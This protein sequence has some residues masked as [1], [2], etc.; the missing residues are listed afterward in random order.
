MSERFSDSDAAREALSALADGEAQSP[1]VARACAAW[2]DQT[3]ARASWHAYQ[4]IGDVMRSEDLAHGSRGD[5]FLKNFRERMAQEPVV[6]APSAAQANRPSVEQ[7]PQ[8]HA[9]PAAVAASASAAVRPLRRRAWA[10]P[11]AVAA[12]FVM[13]VGALMSSQI[14][15]TGSG[16]SSDTASLA[17][18]G[19]GAPHIGDL[20]L[21][22]APVGLTANGFVADAGR[23]QLLS[24][25][26]GG[27]LN[28]PGEVVIIRNP[29]LEQALAMQRATQMSQQGGEL[30][31]AGQ[32]A[33][34]RQV[35]FDGR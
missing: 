34:T 26:G 16:T 19:A 32:G 23:P 10:G 28:R 27:S 3:D 30:S 18:A 13:M 15:P 8:R 35:V 2:R 1:E 7:A 9:A 29:Q 20:S 22:A 21:T 14:L 11:A 12:G 5:A 6:L 31:F 24:I 17:Q 33:L 25:G 4:L